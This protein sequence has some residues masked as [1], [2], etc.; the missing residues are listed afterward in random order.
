MKNKIIG[1]FVIAI[2]LMISCADVDYGY[3]RDVIYKNE[4]SYHIKYYIIDFYEIG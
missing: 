2:S 1:C 4:S 3:S